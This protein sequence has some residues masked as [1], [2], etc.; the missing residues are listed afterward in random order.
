M[1]NFGAPHAVL[2]NFDFTFN[3]HYFYPFSNT[4][5]FNIQTFNKRGGMSRFTHRKAVNLL[6]RYVR[7]IRDGFEFSPLTTIQIA[8]L[9]VNSQLSYLNLS[10][11]YRNPNQASEESIVLNSSATAEALAPFDSWPV[12]NSYDSREAT[13]VN[14]M[15]TTALF[16][17]LEAQ[18]TWRYVDVDSRL[19]TSTG[20]GQIYL[21]V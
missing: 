3:Q 6:D 2:D 9:C 17:Q 5:S 19:T 11:D 14:L 12:Q 4:W 21:G 20:T 18:N 7:F 16:S 8:E 13:S 1:N 10:V 15:P